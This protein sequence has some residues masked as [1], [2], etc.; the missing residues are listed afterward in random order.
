MLLNTIISLCEFPADLKRGIW[1]SDLKGGLRTDVSRYRPV[2]VLSH[3]AKVME[4]LMTRQ[5]S[6]HVLLLLSPFQF[7]YKRNHRTETPLLYLIESWKYAVNSRKTVGVISLD[8]TAAFDS[9]PHA[10][11]LRKL[12]AYGMS[13]SAFKLMKSYFSFLHNCVRLHGKQSDRWF[14]IS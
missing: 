4:T 1:T 12:E 2:T 7:A 3:V 6:G 9:M 13:C 8:L 10:L 14:Q 5:F 11:L